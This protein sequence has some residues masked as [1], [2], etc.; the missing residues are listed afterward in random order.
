MEQLRMEKKIAAALAAV[1]QYLQEEQAAAIQS[2]MPQ[3]AAAV[4]AAPIRLW[5][6]SGRQAQMANR[7]LMQMRTFR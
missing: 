2:M 5:G 6:F 3:A 4:P 1:E 7:Q